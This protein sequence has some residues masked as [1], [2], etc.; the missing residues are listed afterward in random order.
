MYLCLW[1]TGMV[2]RNRSLQTVASF[3]SDSIVELRRLTK[4]QDLNIHMITDGER[5]TPHEVAVSLEVARKTKSK[6][7][8]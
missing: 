2:L 5:T 6:L 4:K 1:F 3:V 8:C 7:R